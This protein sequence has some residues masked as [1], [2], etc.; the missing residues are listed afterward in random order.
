MHG[1]ANIKFLLNVYEY[2]CLCVALD[3]QHAMHMQHAAICD[4]SESTIFL[5]I[6]S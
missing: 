2:V 3:T 6:I 4:L 5:N 1:Q